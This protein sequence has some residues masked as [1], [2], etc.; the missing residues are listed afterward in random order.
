MNILLRFCA[1]AR[2]KNA[3]KNQFSSPP[4]SV[5]HYNV[6]CFFSL[7]KNLLFFLFS[8]YIFLSVLYNYQARLVVV[9]VTLI[10]NTLV[11]IV[12]QGRYVVA[13]T[14]P[15]AL[16]SDALIRVRSD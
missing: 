10:E 5:G 2:E 6:L 15:I 7:F 3:K 9:V 14:S 4:S 12:L 8:V 11:G 1:T 13:S 16:C